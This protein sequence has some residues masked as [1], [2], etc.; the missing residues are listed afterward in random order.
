VVRKKSS[1]NE[2]SKGHNMGVLEMA[3]KPNDKDE[4]LV[5]KLAQILVD[6]GLTEIEMESKGLKI[7]VAKQLQ[8]AQFLQMPSPAYET[9]TQNQNQSHNN[10]SAS[11][12]QIAPIAPP[13]DNLINAVNSPMV[14]T[15]YTAP[16]P[17]NPPFVKV[18]DRVKEG[19][20]LLIIEAM[21]V[22]NPI[23][24][25]KSGIVTKIFV[26]DGS[27]VEFGEPLLILE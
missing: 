25:I 20:V 2:V 23:P 1:Q 4:D 7:R 26:E 17:G 22:M 5:R 21:K 8:Q 16:K 15:V 24:A 19:D 10:S 3:I 6:T 27:P 13:E 18:G 14:G 12:A 11:H 9:H